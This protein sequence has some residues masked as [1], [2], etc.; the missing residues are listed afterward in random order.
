MPY[1]PHRH[2]RHSIRLRDYQYDTAGC[3]CVTICTQQRQM[4]FGG[5]DNG[6]MELNDVGALVRAE[7]LALVQRFPSIGLDDFILM[8][9]H[10]HGIIFLNLCGE[11]ATGNSVPALGTVV[12]AFKSLSTRA[13]SRLTEGSGK[14]WQRNYY[15]QIIRSETM[16]NGLRQ[17]ILD[18]PYHW[19]DD[20]EYSP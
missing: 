10:L 8:P 20:P 19:H 14:V 18:N 3:Y 4:M 15:E 6:V 7:W 9:N 2:H 17:Y 13:M 16:L 11:P 1:D 5:V 12:G